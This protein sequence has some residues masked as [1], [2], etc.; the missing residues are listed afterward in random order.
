MDKEDVVCMNNGV[1]PIK[2]N[3]IFPFAMTWMELESIMLREVSHRKTNIIS[4]LK[5]D[6]P[7][8]RYNNYKHMH[9]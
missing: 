3:K 2:K 1:L 9:T 7:S 8:R 5:R 6:N 4:F